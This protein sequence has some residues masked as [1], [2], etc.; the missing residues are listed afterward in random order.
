MK[1]ARY[2]D[3]GAE[4]PGL[5]DSTGQ[6]RDLSSH[7]DDVSSACLAAAELDRLRALDPDGLPVVA[8][9][10]RLGPCVVG[11]GKLVAIGLN[12]TDHAEEAGMEVPSE[13]IVFMKATSSI[14]GPTD[15]IEIPKTSEKTDWEVELGVVI[16]KRAKNIVEA[17]A[18]QHIA[19]Y[20]TVNDVSERAFQAERKG[21]W[22]KGKS[23][24][25]HA[26]IGPWMVTADEIADP[27]N[28]RLWCE[29]DGIMR[30]D[31]STSTMVYGVNFLVAYLSEF[32]TLEPGDVIAT[33][34]PPGVGLG[35][36]PTPVFL[37]QGQRLRC[38]VEGLGEQDHVMVQN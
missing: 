37:K 10:P 9:S 17:E 12:Y 2:G 19:G 34:T 20:C 3:Q 23:H 36:K 8:G 22:T 27:Q 18:A 13:P 1:L 38:G 11:V 24:D 4:R 6:L 30:Q 16:G 35:M 29:V 33:G 7:I 31:G 25:T 21:Q 5:I 28:L 15:A 32:M 26:P 14:C